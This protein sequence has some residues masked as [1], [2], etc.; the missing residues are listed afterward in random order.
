VKWAILDSNNPRETG[1]K[2]GDPPTGAAKSA[3]NRHDSAPAGGFAEAIAA[4]IALPLSDSEKAEAVRR[5]LADRAA[6]DAAGGR[7]EA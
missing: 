2:P 1:G 7:Q 5:L 4:V 3:A 6:A